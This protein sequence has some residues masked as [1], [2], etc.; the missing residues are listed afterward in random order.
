MPKYNYKTLQVALLFC[1]P[2]AFYSFLFNAILNKLTDKQNYGT[3]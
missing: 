3:N 2:I 1:E